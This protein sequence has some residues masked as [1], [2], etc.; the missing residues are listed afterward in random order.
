M[1]TL[2]CMWYLWFGAY[3]Y[4]SLDDANVDTCNC[5]I[6]QLMDLSIR[7]LSMLAIA[8]EYQRNKNRWN[9]SWG[10]CG[11]RLHNWKIY[12]SQFG[13]IKGAGDS[14]F[15]QCCM[16]GHHHYHILHGPFANENQLYCECRSTIAGSC[17]Y[18]E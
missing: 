13:V 2:Y 14:F 12:A 18:N 16:S 4:V 10:R 7:S 9:W 17:T 1:S 15:N 8:N 6:I 11:S 5:G 3:S